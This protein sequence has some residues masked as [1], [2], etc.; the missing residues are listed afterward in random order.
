MARTRSGSFPYVF[1]GVVLTLASMGLL[2]GII[3]S[4]LVQTLMGVS[5]WTAGGQYAST[6]RT[7]IMEAW[8]SFLIVVVLGSIVQLYIS[9]RVPTRSASFFY[10]TSALLFT[11][12]MFIVW[13]GIFPKLLVETFSL[14]NKP[15]VQAGLQALGVTFAI[16][17]LQQMAFTYVPGLLLFGMALYYVFSP[18]RDDVYGGVPH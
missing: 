16:N 17:F 2:W 15:Y 12:V 14:T 8:N 3:D 9:S 1:L 6:S 10:R 13:A 4:T 7:Y 5:I 18:I 11:Y